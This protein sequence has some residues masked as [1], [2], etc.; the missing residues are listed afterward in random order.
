MAAYGKRIQI[1]ERDS[2]NAARESARHI[3]SEGNGAKGCV[4]AAAA[5]VLGLESAIE[6][7]ILC[8]LE[9]GRAGIHVVLCVDVGA[10]HI[11]RADSVDYREMA[12]IEERFER[13]K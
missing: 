12:S 2:R 8:A 3:G 11:G 9:T 13:S 1:A 5:R 4:R 7:A 10:G 6:P